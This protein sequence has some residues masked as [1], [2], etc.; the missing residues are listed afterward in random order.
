LRATK[1]PRIQ[2]IMMAG[3]PWVL[4]AMKVTAQRMVS[5]IRPAAMIARSIRK[6]AARSLASPTC[7]P[8][9]T[10]SGVTSTRRIR[11]EESGDTAP[12]RAAASA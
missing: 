9:S 1:P 7:R 2:T 11:S 12:D 6:A 3:P 4:A 8:R 10:P 5:R